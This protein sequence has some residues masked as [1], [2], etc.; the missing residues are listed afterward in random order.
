MA[1]KRT[2][3]EKGSQEKRGKKTER[4][5]KARLGSKK[6]WESGIKMKKAE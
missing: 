2:M 3:M 6:R 5:G 4:A 1:L